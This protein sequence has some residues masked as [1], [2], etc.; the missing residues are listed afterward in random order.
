METNDPGHRIYRHGVRMDAQDLTDELIAHRALLDKEQFAVLIDR[1]AEK[2]TRYLWRLG[3]SVREDREDLLQN[4]FLNAYRNLNSFDSTLSFSSWIYRVVH[5]EAMS[6]FRRKKSRPEVKLDA[7][8]ESLFFAIED[9]QAD[10]SAS[11]ELRLSSEELS[12]ALD[13]LS[14]K[15][16]E[17][18]ALRF[19]EERS[20]AEI[21]DIL[22]MPIGT[23]STMIHRA[24][25]ALRKQL[26]NRLP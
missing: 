2:L 11:T 1:Y 10:A 25:R 21:S 5:N 4:A 23:V 14:E 15:Y 17:I 13:V 22:Q 12:R 26:G 7:E 19:F 3:V 20:Y 6:F 24:K 16:R 9:E 18:L 8:G